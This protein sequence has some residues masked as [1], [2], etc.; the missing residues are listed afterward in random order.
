MPA[1]IRNNTIVSDEWCFDASD[2]DGIGRRRAYSLS[3]WK[4]DGRPA[5]AGVQMEP[6]DDCR[7]LAEALPRLELIAVHFP[8]FTDGRGFS[9]ARELRDLGYRGELRAR[10]HI[11]PDQMHFLHRC[12][13]DA[14]QPDDSSRLG[15]SL[16][17]L[18]GFSEH[19]QAAV[20][21]PLP[22]FR[23]RG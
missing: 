19:Y 15:A 20:D 10:G 6:G 13:F 21:Q 17:R 18:Q 22:L 23:R 3:E 5:H 9:M 4:E 11:L 8:A 1:L 12:G 7:E 14:F 2:S 16:E